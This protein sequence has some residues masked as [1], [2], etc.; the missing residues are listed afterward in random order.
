MSST[1]GG[2]PIGLR[3]RQESSVSHPD[4]MRVGYVVNRYPPYSETFIVNEILAH[5]QAGLSIEIFSLQPPIDT[6]FQDLIASVRSPVRYEFDID[7][8]AARL[9]AIFYAAQA[10]VGA[11]QGVY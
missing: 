11:V 6:H 9:P 8:D 7:R 10:G 5:A 2:K 4:F 1:N 3:W